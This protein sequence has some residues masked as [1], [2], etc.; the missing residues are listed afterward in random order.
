MWLS[1]GSWIGVY[2]R[3][4]GAN[5][6]AA[7]ADTLVQVSLGTL[8]LVAFQYLIDPDLDVSRL[9]VGLFALYDLMFLLLY[10]LPAG[11]VRGYIRREFGA[12][13]YYV[14]VG[15]ESNAR[16]MGRRLEAARDTASGCSPLSTPRA[17][18]RRRSGWGANTRR[19]PDPSFPRYCGN[20]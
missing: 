1:L 16:E 4:Y 13:V 14:I 2:R 20:T 7:V 17:T 18:G 9:F 11:R 12:E 3:L 19:I 10:R 6:V 8:G 15:V 5:A